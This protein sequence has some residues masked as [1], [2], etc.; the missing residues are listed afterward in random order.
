MLDLPIEPV[1]NLYLGHTNFEL[2]K[3][4][5]LKIF[6]SI[7]GIEMVKIPSRYKVLVGVGKCFDWDTIRIEIQ[8][9]LTCFVVENKVTQEI[10]E[11]IKERVSELSKKYKYWCMY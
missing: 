7:K 9:K 2:S 1:F 6:D 4:R 3:K 10:L 5:D 11:K 8:S